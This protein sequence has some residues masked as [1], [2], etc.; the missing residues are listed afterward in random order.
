MEKFIGI[1][2]I[3]LVAYVLI[4]FAKWRVGMKKV[5]AGIPD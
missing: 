1:L 3:A 2:V 4:R 5:K